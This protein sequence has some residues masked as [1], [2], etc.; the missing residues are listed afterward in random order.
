MIKRIP[1]LFLFLAGL[2]LQINAQEVITG[3]FEN[4]AVKEAYRELMKNPAIK[5][6]SENQ[7]LLLPFFDDFT[8]AGVYPDQHKWADKEAFVNS[9]I[10]YRSANHGVA[11]LDAV[12]SRGNLYPNASSFPFKADSL[13]SLPIRLDSLFS[14]I[15]KALSP[16]DSV[17]FSFFYQ[18]QGRT[19]LGP[20]PGDSLVLFFGHETGNLVFANEF[21]SI[22]VPLSNF[23]NPGDTVFPGDT[24]FSPQE[25]NNGLFLV[26][27]AIYTYNDFVT[28]PCDSLFKPEYKWEHVW[29]SAGMTL[30]NFHDL[31]KTYSK[32]VLIPVRDSSYFKNNFQFRFMN[33]ASL[34]DNTIPSWRSNC[35]QWNV[36]YVYLNINRNWHDTTYKDVTFVERAPSVLKNYEAMPYKQYLNDPSNELKDNLEMFISDLDTTIYNTTYLYKVFEVNG[37]FEYTYNGGNCNL[38]PVYDSGYQDC[39]TCAQHACP[40]SNFLFPLYSGQD[41]AEFEIRHYIIGDLTPTDTVADTL[42]FRQKFFNYYAYDDGTPEAGYWLRPAGSST[43]SLAYRFKL[44]TSDTLRAVQIYFN[45]TKESAGE[46]L[47]NLMVWRDNNGVPGDVIYSQ[48]NLQA[49]YSQNLNQYITYM[50]NDPQPLNGIFYIGWEEQ[51]SSNLNLGFD[52]YNNAKANTFYNVE[53]TWQQSTADGAVMMRPMLGKAFNPNGI[54]EVAGITNDIQVYPN[55]LNGNQLHF[56]MS[57]KYRE[58]GSTNDLM[59]EIYNLLGQSVW[60]SE[61]RP[62]IT[63]DLPSRGIYILRVVGK[64][65]QAVLSTKLI[66][67]N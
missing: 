46:K 52:T 34:A 27:N 14:P 44:N 38:Y 43:A 24:I 15:A 57:G 4:P 3:L 12:D 32:Q 23:I 63:V 17:Y 67:N 60:Q 31:Y 19:P 16:A 2:S 37:P 45:R 59:V 11:T 5:S 65:K 53:G 47:F 25:C 21:D 8:K 35:D 20:D 10:A 56:R 58:S 9:S 6:T 66:K 40:P 26:S 22:T 1:I 29:S 13:T 62:D 28:L 55:P 39:A 64:D 61:F 42:N 51:V 30:Q 50:L 18:P 36:D 54:N 49:E 33:Y 41:S 7:A 48:L